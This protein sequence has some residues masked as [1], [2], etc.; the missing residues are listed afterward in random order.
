MRRKP[1]TLIAK[2]AKVS[3]D[4]SKT[5]HPYCQAGYSLKAWV[6]N[7][8]AGQ[9]KIRMVYLVGPSLSINHYDPEGMTHNFLGN[10]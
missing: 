6:E 3:D 8:S 10:K 1:I 7:L 9:Q 5:Y 4:A 2:Q